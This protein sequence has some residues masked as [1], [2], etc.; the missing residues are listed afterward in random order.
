MKS[1]PNRPL[2]EQN[3]K[4]NRSVMKLI[5]KSTAALALSISVGGGL[6]G[7]TEA[8]ASTNHHSQDTTALKALTK[9][10]TKL[11]NGGTVDVTS[12]EVKIPGPINGASGNPI[13]FENGKGG[14][15][16]AAYTQEGEPNFHLSPEKTAS[17]MAIVD[18][19]SSYLTPLTEA[20]L[21]KTGILVNEDEIPVGYSTGG[22]S[23]GK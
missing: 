13:I 3:K 1:N 6:F 18:L 2:Q 17:T 23:T 20:H 7:A 11:D 14:T 16:Y 10:I 19:G 12:L 21:D 9:D 8:S 22:E 15:Y 4:L 5:G